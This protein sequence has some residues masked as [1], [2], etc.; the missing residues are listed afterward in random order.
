MHHI[1]RAGRAVLVF[2]LR[3]VRTFFIELVFPRSLKVYCIDQRGDKFA[4]VLGQDGRDLAVRLF[5]YPCI[6][7]LDRIRIGDLFDSSAEKFIHPAYIVRQEFAFPA[8]LALIEP[9]RIR[10]FK[11]HD[12]RIAVIG[13]QQILDALVERIQIVDTQGGEQFLLR[14]ALCAV[15]QHGKAQADGIGRHRPVALRIQFAYER[16]CERAG[17]LRIRDCTCGHSV[18]VC[19]PFHRLGAGNQVIRPEFQRAG[20]CTV[21]IANILF[22]RHIDYAVHPA[23]THAAL[24]PFRN[25]VAI[26]RAGSA[27]RRQFSV[28]VVQIPP[29]ES[30]SFL[31]G[32]R[33]L[34][35]Q[36]AEGLPAPVAVQDPLVK[37]PFDLVRGVRTVCKVLIHVDPRAVRYVLTRVQ[38]QCL[39][40]PAAGRGFGRHR[41]IATQFLRRARPGR[42]QQAKREHECQ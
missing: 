19:D 7:P 9:E 21:R 13:F 32:D 23:F 34:Q 2:E 31:P 14:F 20:H 15:C 40:E 27:T 10:G 16:I 11:R 29:E 4:V 30:R 39:Q 42:Q 8:K 24:C 3:F 22:A 33:V 35:P 1:D 37:R 6:H 26:G 18:G 38:R 25:V 36:C 28:F 41:R 17:L 12:A 5:A